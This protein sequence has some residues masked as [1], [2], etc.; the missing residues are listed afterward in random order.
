MGSFFCT[1]CCV[2]E[3]SNYPRSL[4]CYANKC[5]VVINISLLLLLIS[6]SDF[7]QEFNTIKNVHKF[8]LLYSKWLIVLNF[9]NCQKSS[10]HSAFIFLHHIIISSLFELLHSQNTS[11]KQPKAEALDERKAGESKINNGCV[12][13]V[14]TFMPL[15]ILMS[16]VFVQ[17]TITKKEKN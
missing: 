9:L 11:S 15:C 13:V 5:V 6:S 2:Q 14:V 10:S 1:G 12:V 4:L 8:R 7:W 3:R 17:F 16:V